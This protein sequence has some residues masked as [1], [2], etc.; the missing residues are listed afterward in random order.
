MSPIVIS[1]AVDYTIMPFTCDLKVPYTARQRY[2]SMPIVTSQINSVDFTTRA[3]FFGN[4]HRYAA[5]ITQSDTSTGMHS[6]KLLR[7]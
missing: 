5:R 6:L 1:V 4:T 2:E 7:M 3:L